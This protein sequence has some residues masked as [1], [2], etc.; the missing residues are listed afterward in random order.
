MDQAVMTGGF[1]DPAIQSAWGFRAAMTAMARP[2]DITTVIGAAGACA[3]LGGG[4][5]ASADAVRSDTPVWLAPS[6]DSDA[7]RAGSPFIR[8]RPWWMRA[9]MRSLRWG[10]GTV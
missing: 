2:G 6:H 4:F 3:R 1:S 10:H 9:G 7:L 8:A 5:G